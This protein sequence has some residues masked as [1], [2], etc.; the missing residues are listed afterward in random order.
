MWDL[1][2]LTVSEN[3]CAW[4]PPVQ[5]LEPKVLPKKLIFSTGVKDTAP[6][7]GQ[8][9]CT[10]D[11]MFHTVNQTSLTSLKWVSAENSSPSW[12]DQEYHQPL[13]VLHFSALLEILSFLF[14]FWAVIALVLVCHE[15]ATANSF[16]IQETTTFFPFCFRER[17]KFYRR[18]IWKKRNRNCFKSQ[19]ITLF[20]IL[21]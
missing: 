1:K 12:A 20:R 3:V 7:W 17:T 16:M 19:H 10:G 18:Y 2:G 6:Y 5:K 8:Q 13:W 9:L 4:T 11:L 14:V 21:G 15:S